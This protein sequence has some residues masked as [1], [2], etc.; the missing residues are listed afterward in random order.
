MRF[1]WQSIARIE[2]NFF[3]DKLSAGQHA[4]LYWTL[5]ILRLYAHIVLQSLLVLLS[6]SRKWDIVH[7]DQIWF[8]IGG[9]SSQLF[10]TWN[11]YVERERAKFGQRG[12]QIPLRKLTDHDVIS[13]ISG[14]LLLLDVW[15]ISVLVLLI[16]VWLVGD[17]ARRRSRLSFLV[18][19]EVMTQLLHVRNSAATFNV[20]VLFVLLTVYY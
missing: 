12:L 9:V 17:I 10:I 16:C 7:R 4:P 8:N 13:V 5:V 1:G 6:R 19:Y 3:S 2:R 20:I 11:A 18:H 14:V 15:E